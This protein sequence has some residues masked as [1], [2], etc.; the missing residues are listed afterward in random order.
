MH[1]QVHLMIATS[2]SMIITFALHLVM[3]HVPSRHSFLRIY[4]IDQYRDYA[5]VARCLY[6]KYVS[7]FDHAII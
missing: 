1:H 3:E 2:L 5:L 7:F 6:N 4:W